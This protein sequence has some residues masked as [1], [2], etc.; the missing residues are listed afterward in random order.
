LN[1]IDYADYGLDF[2]GDTLFTSRKLVEEQP[3]LVAAMVRASLRGWEYAVQH[4]EEAADIV[5]KHDQTGMQTRGHQL[6]MM[7][8]IAKLVQVEGRQLGRSD[9]VV[10][11]RTID[12]LA[13]FGVLTN[14]PA[15]FDVM[16]NDFWD[17]A[18]LP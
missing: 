18:Q 11:Q 13:Q 4:P 14:P 2:P 9:D 3:R 5:L 8:E 10:L 17:Q 1:I 6:S 7:I 16:T 15:A 12:T